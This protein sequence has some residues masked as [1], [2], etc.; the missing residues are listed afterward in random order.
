MSLEGVKK[1]CLYF[2]VLQKKSVTNSSLCDFWAEPKVG[3][4]SRLRHGTLMYTERTGVPCR[5]MLSTSGSTNNE[6]VQSIFGTFGR[7]GLLSLFWFGVFLIFTRKDGWDVLRG[8]PTGSLWGKQSWKSHALTPCFK[9]KLELFLAQVLQKPVLR[10]PSNGD[11]HV[12]SGNMF[13]AW[14]WFPSTPMCNLYQ[15]CL[16]YLLSPHTSEKHAPSCS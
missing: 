10:N 16:C 3:T 7:V 14:G 5:R 9:A 12:S 2:S 6:D 13:R 8:T 15:T 4:S 11:S 1:S